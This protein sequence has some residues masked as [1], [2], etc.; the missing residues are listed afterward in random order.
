M[1]REYLEKLTLQD[2]T[3][4][5]WLQKIVTQPMKLVDLGGHIGVKWYAY[6]RLFK[7]SKNVVLAGV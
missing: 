6:R 7:K 4:L 2:Y 1:Y 3:F 5:F